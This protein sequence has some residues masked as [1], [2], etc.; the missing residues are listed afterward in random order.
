VRRPRLLCGLDYL[1]PEL[2]DAVFAGVAGATRTTA[3]FVFDAPARFT[4]TAFL[5]GPDFFAA[6]AEAT[7]FPAFLTLAHRAL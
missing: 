6:F 5:A 4:G 2:Y 7:F 1:H 3:A